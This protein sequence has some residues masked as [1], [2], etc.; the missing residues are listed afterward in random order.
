MPSLTLKDIPPP[1]MER[2]R[3]RAAQD[4]RS[5]NREAI[6]LLEQAL[7]SFSDPA[8]QLRQETAAQLGAWQAL[9]GRWQGSDQETDDLVADIYQSRT[10]G[11]EFSL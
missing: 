2:L 1:L 3:T 11:R 5:L 4:Q 8:T 9:A 6:W 7:E 10:Q